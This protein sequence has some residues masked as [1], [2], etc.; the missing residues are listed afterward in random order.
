MY[1]FIYF[2]YVYFCVLSYISIIAD[3]QT[4]TTRMSNGYYVTRRLF[5]ADM[6]R[7]VSNCKQ[8]NLPETEYYKCAVLFEKYF[9]A[10]MRE[11]GLWDK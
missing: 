8:Y 2:G 6:S 10:R 7:I 9:Q 3:L 5:I 1:L 4:I 11:S